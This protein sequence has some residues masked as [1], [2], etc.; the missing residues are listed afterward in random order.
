MASVSKQFFQ[1][2]EVLFIN[3]TLSKP[4]TAVSTVSKAF[5]KFK[6]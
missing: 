2:A 5:F 1:P 4:L 6:C 3:I